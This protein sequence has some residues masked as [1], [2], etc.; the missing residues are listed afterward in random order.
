MELRIL[1]G[2]IIRCIYGESLDLA[3]LGSLQIQRASHV[4][5]DAH[6]RWLADLGPVGGPQLGPFPRRTDALTAEVAWLTEHWL[7]RGIGC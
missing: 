6:G 3:A 1:P 4:E 2:G 7:A 5:P